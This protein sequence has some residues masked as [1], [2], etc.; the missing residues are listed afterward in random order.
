MW[1]QTQDLW[2]QSATES[3]FLNTLLVQTLTDVTEVLW[4]PDD[5]WS[6]LSLGISLR[7]YCSKW[8]LG[9]SPLCWGFMWFPGYE[10]LNNLEWV[11]KSAC[12]WCSPRHVTPALP[13]IRNSWNCSYIRNSHS[14]INH[15]RWSA[16]ISPSSWIQ[17]SPYV[18]KHLIC[19]HNAWMPSILF[20]DKQQKSRK[21]KTWKWTMKSSAHL[22]GVH[23][24]LETLNRKTWSFPKT[25]RVQVPEV[26]TEL[27]STH[28]EAVESI[29]VEE[30]SRL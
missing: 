24:D 5:C 6:S 29:T 15:C 23:D 3:R 30:P 22:D 7:R 16:L 12:M 10:T 4:I 8:W 13:V 11:L 25:V 1:T 2:P 28:K 18:P 14:C 20:P 21:L 26:H 27:L 9:S 19:S 17:T